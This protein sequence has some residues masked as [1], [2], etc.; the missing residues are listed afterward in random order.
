LPQLVKGAKW[1][2][3]WVVV[4]PMLRLVIPP[5]AWDEY[6]F[7]FG[8]DALFIPGSQRSGGYGLSSPQLFSKYSDSISLGLSN[9]LLAKGCFGNGVVFLPLELK[10]KP[11]ERLLVVRG[12]GLALGLLNKGLIYAEACKHPDLEVFDETKLPEDEYSE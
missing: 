6:G 5:E 8:E 3:G 1:C 11:G 10:L 7:Q 4:T 12:S 2:F 9:R